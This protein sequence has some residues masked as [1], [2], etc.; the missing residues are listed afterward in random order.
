M[1]LIAIRQGED[2]RELLE[3]TVLKLRVDQKGNGSIMSFNLSNDETQKQQENCFIVKS[4]E[5]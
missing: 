5:R 2:G 3:R 1:L 4:L